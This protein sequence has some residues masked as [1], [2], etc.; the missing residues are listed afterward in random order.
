MYIRVYNFTSFVGKNDPQS[1]F[2][3][4]KVV[5]Y[6]KT[7]FDNQH[8]F[9]PLVFDTVGY[10]TLEVVNILQRVIHNN[11]VSLDL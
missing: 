9:T 4:N 2:K 8:I 7:C 1:C 6:E 3:L 11:V 5:N 10:L